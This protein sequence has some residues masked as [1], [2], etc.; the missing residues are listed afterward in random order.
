MGP[1]DTTS[2]YSE[3]SVILLPN[4]SS[5]NVHDERTKGLNECLELWH[6]VYNLGSILF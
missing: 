6:R 4:L 3:I 5:P 1:I 2:I